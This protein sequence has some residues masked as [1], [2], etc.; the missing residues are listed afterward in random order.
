MSRRTVLKI[1]FPIVSILICCAFLEIVAR[2]LFAH[3]TMNF[4]LE[5]WKYA[6][7]VKL[8]HPNP[9]I[10]HRHRPNAHDFLMGVDVTTNSFGLRDPERTLEKPANTTRI[11]MLGDSIVFGWGC[12]QNETMAAR[13]EKSLNT[14]PITPGRKYE[15]MNTGVGNSNTAMEETWFR[16]EGYKFQ[17]D[18]V[19][20]GWFINDAEPTPIP[21]KNWLAYHSYAFIWL[22]STFD[23]MLRKSSA[24]KNY[25]DYYRGLFRDEQPGYPKMKRSLAELSAFCKEHK[26]PV[27][28]LLIPE[29]H[30]LGANYEFKD[31]YA[32]V[33]ADCAAADLPAV[34]LT[35]AFPTD[36]RPQDYWASPS[37]DHPN[38]KGHELMAI[39]IDKVMRA[40]HW[41]Q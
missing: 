3:P 36:G 30:T 31:V 25:Q 37:D 5:M 28:I 12:P 27:H 17:P 21:T 19:L 33:M 34:D 39:K 26:F 40:E 10:G 20:V 8:V 38:G 32:K 15:V 29:L 4:G 14:N 24:R 23:T 7:N 11:M 35:D 16:E 18:C 41:V 1:A 13:L 9:E 22:K 6:K 2:L